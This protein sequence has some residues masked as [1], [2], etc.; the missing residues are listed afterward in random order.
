MY[1]LGDAQGG[2]RLPAFLDVADPL[3][4]LALVRL[5]KSYL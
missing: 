2:A 3:L 4:L 5:L 1:M